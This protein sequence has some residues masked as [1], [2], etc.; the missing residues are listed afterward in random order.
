MFRVLPCESPVHQYQIESRELGSLT[1]DSCGPTV[2]VTAAI[3]GNEPAGVAAIIR[4]MEQIRRSPIPFHGQLH[5]VVGNLSALKS[6]LRYRD[7]DLNRMWK[8]EAHAPA[9]VE[10]AEKRELDE[11]LARVMS[12]SPAP[13]V[14]LDLHSTSAEGAPFCMVSSQGGEGSGV[15]ALV[16]PQILGLIEL[17]PGTLAHHLGKSGVRSYVFEGGQHRIPQ[18]LTN[19]EHAIWLFLVEI[20]CIEAREVMDLAERRAALAEQCA[21]LPQAL[22][23]TYRH[24][25]RGGDEF[26]MKPGFLNFDRVSRGTL[27]AWDRLGEIRAPFDGRILMPLYQ[28]QGADGFFF[29]VGLDAQ[30][31]PERF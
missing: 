3:H 8:E 25:V 14:L 16:V 24:A 29:G 5:A 6:H 11:F 30:G 4:V 13:H 28:G 7:T 27:L 20:G 9:T 12:Q 10:L 21:G 15:G 31:Q 1:G 17:I 26:M 2:L 22:D 23:V 19:L 18:T